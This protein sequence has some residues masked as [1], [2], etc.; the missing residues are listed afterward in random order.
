L[1]GLPKAAFMHERQTAHCANTCGCVMAML[2]S[3]SLTLPIS[4]AKRAV[5]ALR[6]PLTSVDNRCRSSP[7]TRRRMGRWAACDDYV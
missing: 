3:A 1:A 4:A 2:L 5:Y 7:H 6:G